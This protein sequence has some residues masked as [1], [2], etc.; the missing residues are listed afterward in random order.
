M[1]ASIQA[2]TIFMLAVLL[3]GCASAELRK[4]PRGNADIGTNPAQD[5]HRQATGAIKVNEDKA[6]KQFIERPRQ[7]PGAGS[8]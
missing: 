6:A 2:L 7:L 8:N 1:K 5:A 3:T 4:M